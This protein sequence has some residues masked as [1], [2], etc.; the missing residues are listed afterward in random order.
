M[1][2][3]L[4]MAIEFLHYPIFNKL[5]WDKVVDGI[6]SNFHGD[7]QFDN[8]LYLG[9]G[10]FKLLDWRQ[11][12][13]GLKEFGDIYYDLSKLY[14]GMI[15]SYKSIKANKFSFDMSGDKVF[16]QYEMTSTLIESRE[17]FEKF[18]VSN[19]YDLDKIKLITCLY[20]LNMSPLQ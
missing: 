2:N 15:L 7:L 13:G 18:V 5:D 8:V 11:D 16:Y 19:G 12:F 9:D 6:P 1:L 10:D 20:L 17:I 4:S 14:G 3:A